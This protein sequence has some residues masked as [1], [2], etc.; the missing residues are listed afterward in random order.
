MQERL[1]TLRRLRLN[2]RF[3][4]RIGGLRVQ[5][6]SV[7][8]RLQLRTLVQERLF[9]TASA[10]VEVLLDGVECHVEH[11]TLF[12]R[13]VRYRR[14]DASHFLHIFRNVLFTHHIDTKAF[15]SF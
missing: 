2:K 11:S 14:T 6:K 9:E 12:W 7:S 3:D 5:R 10:G 15:N 4:E 13:H 8:Q 1:V